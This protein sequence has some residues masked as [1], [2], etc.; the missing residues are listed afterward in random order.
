MSN[1]HNY[2]YVFLQTKI[3][4][5][6]EELEEIVDEL[7]AKS[8]SNASNASE[9]PFS[10]VEDSVDRISLQSEKHFEDQNLLRV[11]TNKVIIKSV[12]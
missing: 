3:D 12:D 2:I 6:V 4:N 1:E 9:P 11:A 10:P 5:L 8:P 7:A